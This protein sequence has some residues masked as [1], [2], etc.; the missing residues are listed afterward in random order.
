MTTNLLRSKSSIGN[1][2]RHRFRACAS[3]DVDHCT[4]AYASP[5][6][7]YSDPRSYPTEVVRDNEIQ[8][9]QKDLMYAAAAKFVNLLKQRISMVESKTGSDVTAADIHGSIVKHGLKTDSLMCNLL[10]LYASSGYHTQAKRVFFECYFSG[11]AGL[12]VWNT[13]IATLGYLGD[14]HEAIRV[15]S[16]MPKQLTKTPATYWNILV[17]CSHSGETEFAHY[18]LGKI[19]KGL[20]E[21]PYIEHL[22]TYIDALARKNQLK[23]AALEVRSM[24]VYAPNREIINSVLSRC[25]EHR[26]TETAKEF[27]EYLEMKGVEYRVQK[28]TYNKLAEAGVKWKNNVKIIRQRVKGQSWW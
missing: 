9:N 16:N 19:F 24:I 5:V 6:R 21:E 23:K 17:A 12:G 4:R 22:G 3:S 27:S 10:R 26:D 2:L 28:T 18:I 13:Y 1:L 20:W 15:Y 7:H 14:G 25:V 11:Y 8:R